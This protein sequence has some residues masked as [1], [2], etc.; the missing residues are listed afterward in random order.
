MKKLLLSLFVLSFLNTLNAQIVIN[1]TDVQSQ[2]VFGT[3]IIFHVD[4]TSRDFDL[5]NPGGP[6]YWDFSELGTTITYDQTIL[7]PVQTKYGGQF[8]EAEYAFYEKVTALEGVSELWWYEGFPNNTVATFGF[9]SETATTLGTIKAKEVCIPPEVMG[10]FPLSLGTQWSFTG[11]RTYTLYAGIFPVETVSDVVVD[12]KVD[13]YGTMKL[14]GG[15]TVEVLRL[16]EDRQITVHIPSGEDE[17]TRE[18]LFNYFSKEG[19]EVSLSLLSTEPVYSGVVTV[20]AALWNLGGTTTDVDLSESIP[21]E[22][23]L[24]QNY[25]NPFNP[26]TTI[27]FSIPDASFVELK[28]YNILGAEV[29]TIISE[30]R[31]AGNYSEVFNAENLPSGNYI[32]SLKADGFSESKKMTLLK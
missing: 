2:S 22:F 15:K 21:Q 7:D 6:N 14:P 20:E 23:H 4:E 12:Y 31:N 19:D 9:I 13:A 11:Q 29:A 28:V 30:Y 27:Q 16:F 10:V 17:Y 26:A 18:I 8:P 24:E 3:Q 5:G 1:F 32:V 25:P